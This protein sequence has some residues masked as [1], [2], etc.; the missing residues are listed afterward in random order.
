MLG[1]ELLS[2]PAAGARETED[3]R[4][5]GVR[6]FI[7]NNIAGSLTTR[8]IARSVNLSVS[9]LEHLFKQSTGTRLKAYITQ[10][11]LARAATLLTSTDLSVK[12]IAARVGFRSNSHFV[13]AFKRAAG[14]PPGA[15]RTSQKQK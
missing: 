8:A 11:R 5:A 10:A 12:E 6:Q 4:I 1:R 14:T 7:S 15:Y 3:P 13:R 2:H 9:H